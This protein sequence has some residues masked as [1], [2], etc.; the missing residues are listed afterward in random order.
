MSRS[1]RLTLLC[2]DRQHQAFAHRFFKALGWNLRDW[3]P[4]VAPAG[5]GAAEKFVREKFPV[6]LAALRTKG[7]EQVFLVVLI[8][9]DAAGVDGRRAQLE[10]AC[11]EQGI[12]PP[13]EMERVLV[14][15][16]T[17]NI[18][19]WLAYLDGSDVDEMNSSYP[20]LTRERACEPHAQALATMC[21]SGRL[22]PP[23]PPSLKEACI[24]YR[25]AVGDV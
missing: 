2:E 20:R 17:W 9:G 4:I 13:S 25:R 1:V 6:E 10:N 5:R 3:R 22:H 11:R 19:T 16:P 21:G 24:G 18:E 12:E 7:N 15:V 14:C 8:D 23:A